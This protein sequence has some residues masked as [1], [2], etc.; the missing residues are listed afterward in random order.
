MFSAWI[1]KRRE[2]SDI[3]AATAVEDTGAHM[4]VSTQQN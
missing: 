2:N 4:S 1:I 3:A